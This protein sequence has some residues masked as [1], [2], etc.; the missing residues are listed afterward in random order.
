MPESSSGALFDHRTGCASLH[1]KTTGSGGA[2]LSFVRPIDHPLTHNFITMNRLPLC[3]HNS[4]FLGL[5]RPSPTPHT[6]HPTTPPVTQASFSC[7]T[8]ASFGRTTPIQ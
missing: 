1:L 2:D 7:V 3:P 4:H 8:N 6:S 5:V